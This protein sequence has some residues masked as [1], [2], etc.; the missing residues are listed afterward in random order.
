MPNWFLSVVLVVAALI[1]Y[2][3][4]NNLLDNLKEGAHSNTF[5]AA[6]DIR[7]FLWY[8]VAVV[9]LVWYQRS[10]QE[11]KRE[12]IVASRLVGGER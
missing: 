12:A 6:L 8:V 4:T 3:G 5:T 1:G 2:V 10:I 11:L 9:C 7:V